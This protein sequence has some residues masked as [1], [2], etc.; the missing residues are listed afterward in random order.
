MH[1]LVSENGRL[2]E[3][4]NE[5]LTQ[6]ALDN[7]LISEAKHA[8][9]VKAL[10]NPT[11]NKKHGKRWQPLCNL[12]WLGSLNMTSG[13]LDDSVLWQPVLG[14]P[15]FFVGSVAPVI[16]GMDGISCAD[17]LGRYLKGSYFPNGKGKP[18]AG[19]YGGWRKIE[20]VSM[21]HARQ[22]LLNRNSQAGE[23]PE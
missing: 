18:A 12:R 13:E 9:N 16:A 7:K 6:F 10:L 19:H 15:E 14:T 8:C 3:V 5:Q 23:P 21:A 17:T 2:F 11:S 22:L 4:P 1:A 20:N